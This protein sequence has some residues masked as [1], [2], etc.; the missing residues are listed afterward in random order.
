VSVAH[1]DG[2]IGFDLDGTLA[3]YRGWR[4]CQHIGPPIPAMV[5]RLKQY[6]AAGWQVKIFTARGTA[7]AEERAE[8]LPCIER[9][10]EEHLGEVL[11][12]TNVKDYQMVRLYDDRAVQVEKNTGRLYDAISGA[13]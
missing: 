1:T 5:A 10:C 9:W 4:G 13:A 3:E 6:R 2:W 7:S 8:A 12:I 11:P